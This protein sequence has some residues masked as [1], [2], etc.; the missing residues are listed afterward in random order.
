M[1][2]PATTRLV[3]VIAIVAV[4]GAAAA[5]IWYLFLRPSGPAPVAQ[6]SAVASEPGASEPP[7]LDDDT[8]APP[9]TEPG[10]SSKPAAGLEETWTVDPS[11][12]SFADFSNS[13]VGYRVQEELAGIGGQE[14]VGR[15]PDVTGT[16]TLAGSTVT[17]VDITADLTTLESDD[18]RRDNQLQRQAL[19]TGQFP[20]ATFSL[21]SPIDLGSVPANGQPITAQATGDLTL[22]GQTQSVAIPLTATL[23]GDTVTVTGSIDIVFA[24]YGMEK[25]QSFIVLSV[26]DHGIMEFQLH[27]TR[28]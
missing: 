28:G 10:A 16:L 2:R 18:S 12:G 17:G 19:E 27:F 5:G 8:S 24:D 1:D 20:E 25:P 22:H 6:P 26:D 23:N 7:A 11:I 14:A 3:A 13:F 15:T 9:S 4:V 21:T